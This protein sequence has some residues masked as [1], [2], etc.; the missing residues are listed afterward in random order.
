MDIGDER[1]FF[2]IFFREE[3]VLNPLFFGEN[4]RWENGTHTPEFPIERKFSDEDTVFDEFRKEI[5]LATEDPNRD[6][7]V[8]TRSFFANIRWSEIDGDTGRWEGES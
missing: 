6:R 3:Y 5:I 7:E 8:E 2:F 1:G 4:H